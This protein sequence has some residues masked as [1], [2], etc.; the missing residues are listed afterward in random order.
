MRRVQPGEPI[1]I[2]A[3]EWNA[4]AELV[5]SVKKPPVSPLPNGVS[6]PCIVLGCNQTGAVIEMGMTLVLEGLRITPV[7][8]EEDFLSGSV[9]DL[10]YSGNGI[11][12]VALQPIEPGE[13]GPVVISGHVPVLVS[14]S[15]SNHLYANPDGNGYLVSAEDGAVRLSY[16]NS[17]T[18]LGWC[19]AVLGA[20]GGAVVVPE[21]YNGPFKMGSVVY[22]SPSSSS[23]SEEPSSS[24]EEPSS[25][26]SSEEPSSSSSSEEPTPPS[27]VTPFYPLPPYFEN[28][29]V[30]VGQGDCYNTHRYRASEIWWQWQTGL[31]A[32]PPI[33]TS[34]IRLPGDVT[35]AQIEEWGETKES[36]LSYESTQRVATV[37]LRTSATGPMLEALDFMTT[38]PVCVVA[39]IGYVDAVVGYIDDPAS[40]MVRGAVKALKSEQLWRY[41]ESLN[42]VFTVGNF[43]NL[44]YP[45]TTTLYPTAPGLYVNIY[46]GPLGAWP[47]S[48]TEIFVKG[49]TIER[50]FG[51]NTVTGTTVV[52]DTVIDAST[53]MPAGSYSGRLNVFP[54]ELG[55]SIRVSGA[56]TLGSA[57]FALGS[58][59]WNS[60]SQTIYNWT[61]VGGGN[62]SFRYNE[63]VKGGYEVVNY[64]SGSFYI[65]EKDFVLEPYN[66]TSLVLYHWENTPNH[67]HIIDVSSFTLNQVYGAYFCSDYNDGQ[68]THEGIMVKPFYDPQVG[69]AATLLS[70]WRQTA[71]SDEQ[72]NISNLRAGQAQSSFESTIRPWEIG[73]RTDGDVQFVG[74]R[75]DCGWTNLNIAHATLSVPS[76]SEYVWV[77]LSYSSSTGGPGTLTGTLQHGTTVPSS[78]NVT[79]IM[80]VGEI[81]VSSSR[82][83]IYLTGN[84][85][86]DDGSL[87]RYSSAIIIQRC[88]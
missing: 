71:A 80:R 63:Q 29:Y 58:W 74:G 32:I 68:G 9:Y 56:N 48:N 72:F 47:I 81:S 55:V 44:I 36:Y 82:Q 30:N 51:S 33:D 77:E 2:S 49:G 69:G 39:V 25:S 18:G 86:I 24:S 62:G 14:V 52:S 43:G 78:T 53:Q 64:T 12:G 50:R 85:F 7:E 79:Q 67:Y 45:T 35:Y 88:L 70:Y 66:A 28:Y 11:L 17:L 20:G 31:V 84:A 23:S 34:V 21:E 75:I 65:S 15:D 57:I 13:I 27:P 1:R 42:G 5:D 38:I 87:A 16:T 83:R 10:V 59:S 37:I 41:G 6:S 4:V 26:S 40:Q 22:Q 54:F 46:D 8:N 60:T 19:N 73:W 76:T 61:A 3:S